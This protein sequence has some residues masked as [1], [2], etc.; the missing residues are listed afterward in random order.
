MTGKRRAAERAQQGAAGRGRGRGRRALD[1]IRDRRARVDTFGKRKETLKVKAYEL[2]VLCGVDVALVV[3]AADGEGDGGGAAA[4]VWE[5]T[6]GAVLARY[7]ALDPEVRAR[8]THRAYLE[9]GLGKEEAKLARV[10]QA[11]PTGLDPWDKALDGIATEEEA[12]G[13][14]E[15][16]DAAIRATEDRMRALGLPVDGVGAGV[17]LEGVAPLAFAGADGY[18]LHAPG[19]GGDYDNQAIWANDGVQTYGFQ[20]C[21]TGSGGA[22]MDGYHLQITP[23]MYAAG[24][25]NNNSGRLATDDHLYPPRDAG[26][27]QHGYGFHQCAGTD[28]FGIPAGHQMQELLGWGAAQTNLAMWCTEEPHHAMVPV[29]YPSAETGLSYMDM[30]AALGGQGSGGLSCAIGG[31][32][33]F[34]NAPPEL[35][36][37]M[38]TTGCGGGDDLIN[39]PPVAF[40]HAIGG[41]SDNFTNTTPA[42]SLAMSYG[43][44]LTVP[45]GYATQ[46]QTAQRAGSGQQSGSGI[47]LLHYLSKLEEDTQLHLW[48][49]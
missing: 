12:Q 45:G 34:V 27:L 21:T 9:G 20:Q 41:T 2:S 30:T 28:Y 7:R 35:S 13:L 47:E 11:G 36:L 39:A 46:W 16:I 40:S 23:D 26:T 37:A 48:G 42:Q 44:D 6:E 14:L 1:L 19:G 25:S 43:A 4:D 24:G 33:N 49:N 3:A 8:H 5:S 18:P 10:R 22:G 17:V 32:C 38:V 15:A 29:H 31:S